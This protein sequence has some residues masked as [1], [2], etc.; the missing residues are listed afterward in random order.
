ML[1]AAPEPS[2]VGPRAL[3]PLVL[4]ALAEAPQLRALIVQRRRRRR[5]ITDVLLKDT[6]RTLLKQDAEVEMRHFQF[7]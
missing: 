7:Q 2:R 1:S 3:G 6:L 5:R 4:H